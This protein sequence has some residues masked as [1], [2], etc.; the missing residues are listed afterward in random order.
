MHI[1][2]KQDM[3]TP[4]LLSGTQLLTKSQLLSVLI[5][6]TPG[7]YLGPGVYAVTRLLCEVLR[8]KNKTVKC[9]KSSVNNCHVLQKWMPR[10]VFVNW[11]VFV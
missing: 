5:T 2:N 3:I 6:L 7:L 10:R 8:Y 4:G 9:M 11:P 1:H